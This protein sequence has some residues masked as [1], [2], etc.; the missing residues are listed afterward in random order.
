MLLELK[1][2]DI[3]P[4]QKILLR[5]VTWQEFE[6]ILE[7]LGEHR[8]SRIAYN[9]GILEIMTP[10]PEPEGDKEIISDLIKDLLEELDRE[11]YAL[12]STTFKNQQMAQ[13]IEPDN[14]FYIE[15]EAKIR[16]KKQ[17]DLTIDPPP[18]LA[19]E[20]DVTSRSNPTIYQALGVP[21]LW[22]FTKENLIIYVLNNGEYI[23]SESSPHFP[24]L[25]IKKVIPQYLAEVKIFGRNKTMKKFRKWLKS[26]L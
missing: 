8:S 10:L 15:N 24:T 3:P 25:P 5:D 11:F 14:C 16:G 19:L 18:D 13:G 22:R 26:N 2:F 4:G 21:E 1:R 12:G 20:I 7:D 23:E 6:N 9:N 17:I